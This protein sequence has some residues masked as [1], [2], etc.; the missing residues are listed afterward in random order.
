SRS[1]S[2]AP[3]RSVR[4]RGSAITRSGVIVSR[5]ANQK[6]YARVTLRLARSQAGSIGSYLVTCNTVHTPWSAV[7]TS[8]CTNVTETL[9]ADFEYLL[10]LQRYFARRRPT[11]V[12][13]CA[14][15][16][17]VRS[18]GH[19]GSESLDECATDCMAGSDTLLAVGTHSG[20]RAG[21]AAPDRG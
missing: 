4:A 2:A 21:L 14:P 1:K 6:T 13:G 9:H 17:W 12:V 19:V 16:Q 3:A 7:H 15:T 11:A 18:D 5:A 8:F 10:K 20:L